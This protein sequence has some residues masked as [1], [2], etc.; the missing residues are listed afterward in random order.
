MPGLRLRTIR[1]IRGSGKNKSP[2]YAP[3]FAVRYSALGTETYSTAA[4][5]ASAVS[6]G[7]IGRSQQQL[8]RFAVGTAQPC[9]YDP[10][11]AKMVLLTRGP[12]GAYLFALLPLAGLFVFGW[13]LLGALRTGGRRVRTA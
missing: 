10:D 4:P 11:D 6:F 13:V 1:T 8:E 3:E 12:G 2:T 7:W 5:P 9:W